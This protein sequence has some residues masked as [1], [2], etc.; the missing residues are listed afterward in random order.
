MSLLLRAVWAY[1]CKLSASTA[2]S[3]LSTLLMRNES[4]LKLIPRFLKPFLSHHL[5]FWKTQRIALKPKLRL[6]KA[7]A[8]P[9]PVNACKTWPQ[10][11]PDENMSCWIRLDEMMLEIDTGSVSRWNQRITKD[12][13]RQLIDAEITTTYAIRMIRLMNGI[14]KLIGSLI[15][16]FPN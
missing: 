5:I 16:C 4:N 14:A 11:I 12:K 1:F 8:I 9:V 10:K 7:L 15:K 3:P 2:I 13:I 6:Y